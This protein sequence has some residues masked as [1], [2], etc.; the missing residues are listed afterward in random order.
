MID[1]HTVESG[2]LSALKAR[3][4]VDASPKES[5]TNRIPY[6]ATT[7]V[8]EGTCT[9]LHKLYFSLLPRFGSFLFLTSIRLH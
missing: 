9:T 6:R 5:P 7:P 8:S 2:I 1:L 4:K 3:G